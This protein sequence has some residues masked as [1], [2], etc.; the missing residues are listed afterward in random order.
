MR[1]FAEAVLAYTKASQIDVIT[2]SMGVTLGRKVV[3]GGKGVDHKAGTYEVGGS[4]ANK[5]KVF[6]GLA[7]GNLGLVAC[8]TASTITT[9]NRLMG[10][11]LD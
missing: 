4:L 6:I 5:V 1:A 11:S 2:H 9:C 7:G 3:K 10:F 8:R